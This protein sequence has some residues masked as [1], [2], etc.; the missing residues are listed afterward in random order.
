MNFK[1][2]KGELVAITGSNGVGKTTLFRVILGVLPLIEGSMKIGDRILESKHDIRLAQRKI[3][4]VP[5]S[6]KEG[7][8][9]I[10]VIEFVMLGN[11]GTSFSYWKRP[12]IVDKE[13]AAT[14]LD[15]V[16]LCDLADKDCRQLSGGQRQRMNIARA[17]IRE[18]DI[19]LLDE[20]NTHLDPKSRELLYSLIE[21]CRQR[22]PHL[23][24]LM[25]TH[26]L[27]ETGNVVDRICLIND[28]QMTEVSGRQ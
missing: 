18:P 12:S 6:I 1:A 13:K 3:G 27:E 8:L 23:L 28:G 5:Q 17:L 2:F 14:W 10:T 11:W 25:I 7:N 4:F 19:L 21:Q 24:T 15:Y 20:P 26:L 9:P 22:S 16:G